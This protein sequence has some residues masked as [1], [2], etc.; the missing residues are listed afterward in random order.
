LSDPL[1]PPSGQINWCQTWLG[2]TQSAIFTACIVYTGIADIFT[3][4]VLGKYLGATQ[5]P[6]YIG[7]RYNGVAV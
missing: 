5:R 6:R 2:Y 4:S 1:T 3:R 7:P